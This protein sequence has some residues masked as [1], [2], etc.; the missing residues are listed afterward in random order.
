MKASLEAY[1]PFPLNFNLQWQIIEF[2]S[3]SCVRSLDYMINIVHFLG[4]LV[5]LVRCML[6]SSCINFVI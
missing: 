5:V 1:F 3:L 2:Y 6:Y 4:M